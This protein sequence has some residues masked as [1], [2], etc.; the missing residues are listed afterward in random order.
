MIIIAVWLRGSALI[1]WLLFALNKSNN[2]L[3]ANG[4]IFWRKYLNHNGRKWVNE[5]L[6]VEAQNSTFEAVQAQEC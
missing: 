1:L 3:M 2:I 6:T 4:R 5:L